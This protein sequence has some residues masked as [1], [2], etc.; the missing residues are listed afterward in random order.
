M[1]MG[2][3]KYNPLLKYGFQ[4][5]DSSGGGG[6]TVDVVKI[7]EK[8]ILSRSSG[9]EIYL[10]DS[11]LLAIERM[12]IVEDLSCVYVWVELIALKDIAPSGANSLPEG[13]VFSIE[14]PS[15]GAAL[16]LPDAGIHLIIRN[17]VTGAPIN[18]KVKAFYGSRH[19]SL[20][21][22]EPI[23]EGSTLF[24]SGTIRAQ[25]TGLS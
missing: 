3:I 17:K 21:D 8:E 23:S 6:G 9:Y 16:Q 20:Y 11:E 14:N 24:F 10:S 15:V 5:V 18:T 4:E 2:K 22:I 25:K 1:S 12:D 7:M 13:Q 19:V